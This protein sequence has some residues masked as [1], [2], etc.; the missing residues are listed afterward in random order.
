MSK[1]GIC[2]QTIR[3]LTLLVHKATELLDS[4]DPIRQALRR[5]S[6][7]LFSHIDLADKGTKEIDTANARTCAA[8]ISGYL[9]LLQDHASLR[10]IRISKLAKMYLNLANHFTSEKVTAASGNKQGIAPQVVNVQRSEKASLAAKPERLTQVKASPEA[11]EPSA[12]ALTERQKFMLA[13][14]EKHP[15]FPLKELAT[16]FPSLSEKTIRNDLAVLCD[17]GYLERCGTPPRSYYRLLRNAEGDRSYAENL[18]AY[19]EVLPVNAEF[20]IRL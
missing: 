10:N 14:A 6:V 11:E 19:A 13:F 4:Q 16:H 17:S 20:S 1:Q 5:Q 2:I 15:S 7:A 3:K 8:G 12:R 9:E 18:T